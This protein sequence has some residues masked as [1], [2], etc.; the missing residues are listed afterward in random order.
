[1]LLQVALFRKNSLT[2]FSLNSECALQLYSCTHRELSKVLS[3]HAFKMKRHKIQK[4]G[5]CGVTFFHFRHWDEHKTDALDKCLHTSTTYFTS[6]M[7]K[8]SDKSTQWFLVKKNV[9]LWK[10]LLLFIFLLVNFEFL[11]LMGTKY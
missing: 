4:V 1:M 5:R 10:P 9:F 11:T 8:L 7:F 2:R 6:F 3:M